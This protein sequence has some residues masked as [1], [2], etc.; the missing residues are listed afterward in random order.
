M[1][2]SS[3]EKSDASP[4]CCRALLRGRP[5]H[6]LLTA[7]FGILGGLLVAFFSEFPSDGLVG[8]GILEHFRLRLLDIHDLASCAVEREETCR[9]HRFGAVYL[10]YVPCD[11]GIYVAP[12]LLPRRYT[13]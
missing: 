10:F 9:L 1:G 7:V 11:D 2:K 8:G 13:V 5:L 4:L 3:P 6:Y 12:A